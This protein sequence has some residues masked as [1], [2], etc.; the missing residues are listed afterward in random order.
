MRMHILAF[1]YGNEFH[2]AMYRVSYIFVSYTIMSYHKYEII[3]LLSNNNSISNLELYNNI[4]FY[5]IDIVIDTIHINYK[6][7]ISIYH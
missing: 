1:R 3:L 6:M 2:C 7:L 4:V 5:N